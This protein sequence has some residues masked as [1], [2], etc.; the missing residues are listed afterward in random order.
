MGLSKGEVALTAQM[1]DRL[2]TQPGDPMTGAMLG[3]VGPTS[4]DIAKLD[5]P[6]AAK[7]NA[8]DVK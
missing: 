8:E 2:A 1:A 5:D 3:M 4:G 7:T 6:Q